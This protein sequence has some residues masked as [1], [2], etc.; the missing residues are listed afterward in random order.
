MPPKRRPAGD[1]AAA[2]TKAP[3]SAAPAQRA[4]QPAS[5]AQPAKVT[6]AS[7]TITAAAKAR[8]VAPP[9]SSRKRART[10]SALPATAKPPAPTAPPAKAPRVTAQPRATAAA[11]HAKTRIPSEARAPEAPAPDTAPVPE[12]AAEAVGPRSLLRRLL[13]PTSSQLRGVHKVGRAGVAAPWNTCDA[14]VFST[15]LAAIE[16]HFTRHCCLQLSQLTTATSPAFLRAAALGEAAL[17]SPA[18]PHPTSGSG[19][20]RSSDGVT[21]GLSAA[22]VEALLDRQEQAYRTV[23]ATIAASCTLGHRSCQVLWGPRGG[24]KHRLLRLLAQEVRRTPGT[25]VM[26]LHGRLLKDDAAALGVIAEQLLDFLMSPQSAALRAGHYLL[27][28]GSFGFGQLFHYEQRMA[29]ALSSS[30]AAASAAA[31]VG[32]RG[33]GVVAAEDRESGRRGGRPQAARARVASELST[34]S[35]ETADDDDDDDAETRVGPGVLVTSTTT[36]LTG[37]AASALPHLQRALL[38]LK[39]QGCSMVVCIRDID[40]FG[41]RCDQLLYVLSGLM[42]DS[43]TTTTTTSAAA[44]RSRGGAGSGGLSF[45]LASAAPDI[46]Q[47]EKRL[48]SR[49][50]CETRYVPLLPWSLRNLLAATLHT[51]AEDAFL[52]VR[53]REVGRQRAELV[54]ALRERATQLRRAAESTAGRVKDRERA[55]AELKTTMAGLEGRLHASDA[56]LRDLR[57]QRRHLQGMLDIAETAGGSVGGSGSLASASGV[58]GAARAAGLG[59]PPTLGNFIPSGWRPT[60]LPPTPIPSSTAA[61]KAAPATLFTTARTWTVAALLEHASLALEVQGVMAEELLRQLQATETPRRTAPAA[62]EEDAAL[63]A[64]NPVAFVPTVTELSTEL[65]LNSS[66]ASTV[67]TVLASLLC[68]AAGGAVDLLGE[69]GRRVLLTWLRARLQHEPIPPPRPAAADAHCAATAHEDARAAGVPARVLHGWRATAQALAQLP[70]RAATAAAAVVVPNTNAPT[71]AAAAA[72]LQP[73]FDVADATAHEGARA[74]PPVPA[75]SLLPPHL[76]DLLADGQL[77]GMGYGS[78]ELLLVLFY[79]H[80]HLSSGVRQR[81]VA[82]LLED[83]ASSLG[84]KAAAALDREAFR[85]A[86]RQLCRWRLLRVA[87]PHSQLLEVCGS[88]APL[89]EFLATVLSR[90]P[91][92]SA[93]EL[94]LDA[95]E[96]VRL[97]NLL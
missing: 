49:L 43:E 24:G 74:R 36:Y 2:P 97:R 59:L 28:T 58:Q 55:Q 45:V 84:T 57:A 88:T 35:G 75:L 89:R 54:A 93:A 60:G 32:D 19:T 50:T 40:V 11:A 21:S 72:S 73:L 96:M 30:T 67:L 70:R 87:E 85:H 14:V 16:T 82:D 90:Q 52:Q 10:S 20:T 26:E 77:V 18:A 38:L 27:R 91:T 92:S 46:R 6:T 12:A 69:S 22:S 8:V 33:G 61:H 1:A 4:R 47:L 80:V 25:F 3:G 13:P 53:L 71:T 48:S 44:E 42:H 7:S 95:R 31:V 29:D 5:P 17:A 65:E 81:T 79:M 86:I 76:H 15:Y 62:A 83:V 41:V 34:D 23:R 78:R 51:T 37:G 94:G 68:K 9:A 66:P 39:S 56:A 63:G 64:A